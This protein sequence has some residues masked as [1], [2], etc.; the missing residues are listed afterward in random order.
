M[1]A[2]KNESTVDVAVEV[3]GEYKNTSTGKK[4]VSSVHD[5]RLFRDGQMVGQWPAP[6]D[7]TPD[8]VSGA[9]LEIWQSDT[10]VI[11]V[12]G[13]R[14]VK[15]AEIKLPHRM[16]SEPVEFSAYAFNEDR[17]KG[18]TVKETTK[19]A[20]GKVTKKAYLVAVGVNDYLVKWDG[21][22][23]LLHAMR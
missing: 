13:K 20:A 21:I 2:G 22:C 1:T 6:K 5:L 12:G 14:Q 10:R 3:E 17:V 18:D 4:Q 9:E 11:E 7:S 15:F 19:P 16:D 8:G 23:A